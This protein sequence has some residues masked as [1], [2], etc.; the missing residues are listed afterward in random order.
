MSQ[1][2]LS[3]LSAS[4][5]FQKKHLKCTY[6]FPIKNSLERIV[7]VWRGGDYE[8]DS[9]SRVISA[10]TLVFRPLLGAP[11]CNVL[12]EKM[13]ILPGGVLIKIGGG[14]SIITGFGCPNEL[15]INTC[16][17]SLLLESG[18]ISRPFFPGS[19]QIGIHTL[20]EV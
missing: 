11:P 20:M 19:Q 10:L 5:C 3:F 4:K 16:S 13:I 12:S 9:S 14:L 17:H 6:I 18:T 1:S 15:W 7:L 2:A 8:D